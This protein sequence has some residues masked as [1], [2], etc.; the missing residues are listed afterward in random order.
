[1]AKNENKPQEKSNAPI[2]AAVITA[3]ATIIVAFLSFPPL[4][5][6]LNTIWNPTPTI[7]VTIMPTETP[8]T[9]LGI[10]PSE[11]ENLAGAASFTDTP[12][13]P[14][15][16]TLTPIPPTGVMIAQIS[17]N[18]SEGRAPLRVTFRAESSYVTFSDGSVETC[19]FANVCSYTWD[20]RKQ[21]GATIHGPVIGGSEFSYE[22]AQKGVYMVVV[23]VC[24]GQACNFSATTIKT[25]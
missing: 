6:R 24:R 10:L 23:Y 1:M 2:W 22:F 5:A 7:P 18:Y 14:P 8:S 9:S 17:T 16:P 12:V 4:I 19:K 25:K 20:V 13:I 11:T 3:L 21:E 15:P